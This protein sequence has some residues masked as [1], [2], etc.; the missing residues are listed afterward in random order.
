MTR[1]TTSTCVHKS[2][3]IALAAVLSLAL[4]LSAAEVGNLGRLDFPNSGAP[5]AQDAFVRGVLLLHNF[6]YQDAREAFQEAQEIDSDF[7]LAYWGEAMTHNAPLWRRVDQEEARAALDRL[8]PTVEERLAKTP[9]ERERRYLRAFEQLLGDGEKSDRDA[10]Y[11]EAMGRLSAA[12]PEDQEAKAFYA[13]SILG[14]QN[15]SRDFATYM[16]AGA[17]AEEVFAANPR[18]PGAVHYMIHSYDDPVHAPLG[19]RAARVY[20]DISPAASH[21]QHMISHIFVALGQ[22]EESVDSNW[23][24]FEV[25]RERAERKELGADSLN[26]HALQWL[27]Y[28]YLQLGR[29]DDARGLLDQMQGYVTESGSDR[30]RWYHAYMRAAWVVETGRDAPGGFGAESPEFPAQALD[31]FA[32]GYAALEAGDLETA[33][34]AYQLLS[35]TADEIQLD[36]EESSRSKTEARVMEKSLRARIEL[37]EGNAEVALAL[38]SEASEAEAALPLDFG[39]PGIV[40][41]SHE[42]YGEALLAQQRPEEARAQFETA[43]ARAPRRSQSLSGRAAAASALGDD[44]TVERACS[45]LASIRA[46]TG[47]GPPSACDGV[48]DDQS[49][50]TP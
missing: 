39:P 5:E 37:A 46:G 48:G 13:L 42:L 12:H 1:F 40:K 22:W 27:Q 23:K 14:T 16:R 24:S 29:N 19:L 28:S 32:S 35:A 21:A 38:L 17:V 34:A 36:D 47:D 41:P 4:S 9:T 45:E 6:E 25:S 7:S 49:I 44:Q 26:Y 15:G 20:A 10:A 18:H 33:A 2:A 43:L 3:T 30:A 11:S 50:G 8:A 31:H